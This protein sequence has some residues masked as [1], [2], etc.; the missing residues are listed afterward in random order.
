MSGLNLAAVPDQLLQSVLP[1]DLFAAF[2]QLSDV[3]VEG[4]SGTLGGMGL[5]YNEVTEQNADQ[6]LQM[7]TEE[8]RREVGLPRFGWHLP[9]GTEMYDCE[10]PGSMALEGGHDDQEWESGSDFGSASSVFSFSPETGKQVGTAPVLTV[11]RSVS[12]GDLGEMFQLPSPFS[13]SDEAGFA[14]PST[15][16]SLDRNPNPQL[17]DFVLEQSKQQQQQQHE[18][19]GSDLFVKERVSVLLGGCLGLSSVT[20]SDGP[21]KEEGEGDNGSLQLSSAE[22]ESVGLQ[23]PETGSPNLLPQINTEN[24]EGAAPMLERPFGGVFQHQQS[25]ELGGVEGGVETGA[26]DFCMEEVRCSPYPFCLSVSSVPSLTKTSRSE[27][28]RERKSGGDF[29]SES[30][31]SPRFGL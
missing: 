28:A 27:L 9:N 15:D 30:P 3:G 23:T 16:K 2:K 5:E 11:K 12:F 21:A 18:P 6:S 29:D 4:L 25:S 19:V 14:S 7:S 20:T 26:L 22:G 13:C 24:S 1:P 31:L 10:D 8:K 17:N